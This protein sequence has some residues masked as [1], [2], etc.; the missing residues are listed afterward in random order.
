MQEM[1]GKENL[2]CDGHRCGPGADLGGQP[3]RLCAARSPK[4]RK[5]RLGEAGLSDGGEAWGLQRVR[6]L[7][8]KMVQRENGE[9]CG[10]VPT[11]SGPPQNPCLRFGRRWVLSPVTS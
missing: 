1:A 8:E 5:P 11:A 3:D 4:R 2:P 10:I 7:R 6:R 9:G